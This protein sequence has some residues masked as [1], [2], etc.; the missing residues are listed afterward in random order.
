MPKVKILEYMVEGRGPFPSDMFRYDVGEPAD[1]ANAALI[2]A[3]KRNYR[4][5]YVIRVLAKHC[6]VDRWESFGWKVVGKPLTV[7]VGL[8]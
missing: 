8:G 6:T 7:A 5:T 4:D 3:N 1:D 2:E